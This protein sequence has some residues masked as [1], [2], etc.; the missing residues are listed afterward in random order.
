[1]ALAL[2]RERRKT[3]GN[4][5]GKLITEE[6]EDDFYSTTYGGFNEEEEDKDYECVLLHMVFHKKLFLMCERKI[7]LNEI[8]SYT[9][10]AQ[11]MIIR[12][13]LCIHV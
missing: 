1:M 4:R 12:N 8:K 3:A 5:M 13:F 2:T 11:S 10:Q 7:P 6:E 9:L